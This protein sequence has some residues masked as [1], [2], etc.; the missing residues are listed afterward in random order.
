MPRKIEKTSRGKKEEVWYTENDGMFGAYDL[1][2][3]FLSLS[4]DQQ[5][6]ILS[7][8]YE[9]EKSSAMME[10][11]SKHQ[12][13]SGSYECHYRIIQKYA[14]RR[15]NVPR[16]LSDLFHLTF[17]R[18]LEIAELVVNEWIIRAK[19]EKC[20]GG[21]FLAL[22]AAIEVSW[23]RGYSSAKEIKEKG[24]FNSD[25]KQIV[26]YGCIVVGLLIKSDLPFDL[27]KSQA[28]ERLFCLYRWIG[29]EQEILDITAKLEGRE[30]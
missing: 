7:I 28:I 19:K 2:E 20:Y 21:L 12:L 10:V 17:K 8:H 16:L 15:S 14:W 27:N 25:L 1:K 29:E 3:W 22:S 23:Q 13:V 24:L 9:A 11:W 4:L 30:H 6:R 5:S 18:D 26:K